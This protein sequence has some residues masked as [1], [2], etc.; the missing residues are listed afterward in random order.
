MT[1]TLKLLSERE[2]VQ[3]HFDREKI[4]LTKAG[5]TYNVYDAIQE[6]REDTEIMPTLRKYG[7]I[8]RLGIDKEK[9]YGDLT[10]IQE[11]LR[12]VIDQQNEANKLWESLPIETRI[13]YNNNVREFLEKAPKDLEKELKPVEKPVEKP[14]AEKEQTNE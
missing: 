3:Q 7:C 10:N 12:N 13:K 6:A 1:R 4:M 14:V 9:V 11:N 8:D 5:K 2:R